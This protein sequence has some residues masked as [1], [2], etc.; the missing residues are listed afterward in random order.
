MDQGIWWLLVIG[1]VGV[2]T[3]F[4]VKVFSKMV[5]KHAVRI[6]GYEADRVGVWNFFDVPGYAM[7]AIMMTG[8]ISLRAF[9]LVPVWFIAFFYTGLGIALA[10]SG[11]SFLIRFARRGNHPCPLV[12]SCSFARIIA[13]HYMIPLYHERPARSRKS[14]RKGILARELFRSGGHL[15]KLPPSR[16]Y[17]AAPLGKRKRHSVWR[18]AAWR[19]FRFQLGK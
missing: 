14:W 19:G 17:G 12:S 18:V 16:G 6:A 11:A 10:L 9:G 2:F 13:S 7:M 5:G 15:T 1:A 3:L 8:G 4:H